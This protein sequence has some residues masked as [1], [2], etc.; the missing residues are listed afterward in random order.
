[1]A[2]LK[3]KVPENVPGRFYVDDTC[4]YCELCVEMAPTV[5]REINSKGWAAVFHQP[6]T[7]EELEIA[8]QAVE[9]CPTESIGMDGEP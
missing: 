5:F 9:G 3:Y 1:M 6:S 2:A 4:I 7:E 8:R